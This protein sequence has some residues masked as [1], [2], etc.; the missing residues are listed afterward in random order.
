MFRKRL[1]ISVLFVATLTFAI[2]GLY[3]EHQ[4]EKHFY[5]ECPACKQF[6]GVK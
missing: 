4:M 5:E 2:G 3:A 1:A 6:T